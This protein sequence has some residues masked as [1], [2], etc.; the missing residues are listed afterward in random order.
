MKHAYKIFLTALCILVLAWFLQ[1][2]YSLLFPVAVSDPFVAYSPISDCFIVSEPGGGDIYAVDSEGNRLEPAISK[3]ERDSLLPHIYYTQLVARDCLPDTINGLPVSVAQ[4]KHSQW[5]F[6]S[7]PR[8]LNRVPAKIHLMMESMPARFEL[9]DPKEAFRLDG[10]V[11]FIDILTN[12]V[13]QKRSDRFTKQ[14]ARGGF[15]YPATALSANITTRKPYDEGYLMADR[16]GAVFHMKMQA[17]RPYMARVNKP[18]SVVAEHLFILE[19]PDTRQLGLVTDSN[20]NMYVLEHQGYRLLPLAVGKVNP[21][22]DR[23]SIVK[24]LFNWVVKIGGEKGSRWVALDSETYAPLAEY[25]TTYQTS[26]A[27]SIE[28]YIFPFELSFTSVTDCFARPRIDFFSW[29]FLYLNLALALAMYA[30]KRSKSR[31]W[32]LTATAATLIFGIFAFIPLIC[33]KN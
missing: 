31:R 13:N 33:I 21:E 6:S 29:H 18:D 15:E 28:G 19:N 30:L 5:V 22:T 20:H 7:S 9:E 4:F 1:W 32:Q 3:E 27:E 17:G 11:E 24:N 23:I 26:T 2:L 16:K 14:F 12:S 10:K 25:S 8:D